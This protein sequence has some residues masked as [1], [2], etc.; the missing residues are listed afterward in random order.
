LGIPFIK[1][2]SSECGLETLEEIIIEHKYESF[3]LLLAFFTESK[4]TTNLI[5]VFYP[6]YKS[7]YTRE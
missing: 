2:K 4:Y 7:F 5:G 1:R 6:A 3:L